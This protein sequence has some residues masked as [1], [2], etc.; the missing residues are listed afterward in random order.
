MNP[1]TPDENNASQVQSN[2]DALMNVQLPVSI[3]FGQTE[4]ILEDVIA[5]GVGSIIELN[6]TVED[7]VELIVNGKRFA[8]GQV[9]SV[10]GFYGIRITEINK[11]RRS[12]DDFFGEMPAS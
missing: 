3:R 6:A 11:S 12:E 9:V 8:R 4:M 7:P 10:D 2:L 1:A 5:L